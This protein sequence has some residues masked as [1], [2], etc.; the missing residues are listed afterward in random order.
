M[1]DLFRRINYRHFKQD[2]YPTKEKIDEVIQEAIN[3]SP[4]DKEFFS[5]R[6]EVHGPEYAAEKADLVLESGTNYTKD[7]EDNIIG[8]YGIY[9]PKFGEDRWNEQIRKA[10]D[11][12]PGSFNCQ[13]QAP[14]LVSLITHKSVE[15][16]N[17]W[18]FKG[19]QPKRRNPGMETYRHYMNM[20]IF[21]HGLA[22][23]ANNHDIDL[24]FCKCY[25]NFRKNSMLNLESG[26]RVVTLL[27]LGYYDWSL[28]G[29]EGYDAHFEKT[30]DP[31]VVIRKTGGIY[32]TKEHT[33]VEG[34]KVKKPDLDEILS[35]K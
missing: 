32:N 9:V 35:W 4:V 13:I 27:G 21:I 19:Y 29:T 22:M 25:S 1:V 33:R 28:A 20:G 23:S 34:Y 17:P 5:W 26:E 11:R 7:E 15:D 30:D 6:L 16:D 14:Y 24:S 3:I 31:D 12:Q 2:D 8:S 18:E 10:Y